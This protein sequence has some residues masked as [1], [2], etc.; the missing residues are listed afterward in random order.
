MYTHLVA[1][2]V[3]LILSSGFVAAR[4][5]RPSPVYQYRREPAMTPA[6]ARILPYHPGLAVV[7]RSPPPAKFPAA[8]GSNTIWPRAISRRFIKDADFASGPS[9]PTFF[10]KSVHKRAKDIP[11]TGDTTFRVNNFAAKVPSKLAPGVTPTQPIR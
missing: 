10:D 11:G 7:Q 8:S 1:L 4:P 5:L 2:S 9:P 3:F 6:P